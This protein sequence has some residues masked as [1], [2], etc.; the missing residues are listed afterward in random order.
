MRSRDWP[1][2]WTDRELVQA[3]WASTR[4]S[5]PRHPMITPGVGLGAVTGAR[6]RPAATERAAHGGDQQLGGRREDLAA[7]SRMLR[8]AQNTEGA[9][10]TGRSVLG[11]HLC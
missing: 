1:T 2:V 11:R 4:A 7:E 10:V 3:A 5:L 8:A 6:C 9:R